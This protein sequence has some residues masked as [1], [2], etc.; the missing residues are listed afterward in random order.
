[1]VKIETCF[2]N[3]YSIPFL[4]NNQ[5]ILIP[6]GKEESELLEILADIMS[7]QKSSTGRKIIFSIQESYGFFPLINFSEDSP[8]LFAIY[9]F[10]D[11]DK[12]MN[13]IAS[14]A[15]G[16]ASYFI[17]YGGF[18]I[19]GALI[20]KN[21]CGIVLS[22]PSGIGKSTASKRIPPPWCS[23][24][25]DATLILKHDNGSYHAHPW[26]TW[27]TF[28]N[29]GTG[30]KWDTKK[31]VPL[32]GLFFLK[33][34]DIDLVEKIQLHNKFIMVFECI[35]HMFKRCEHNFREP[36]NI[37]EVYK[38][39]IKNVGDFITSVPI[40]LLQNTLSGKFWESIELIITELKS[41][42][43]DIYEENAFL[44]QNKPSKVPATSSEIF[45]DGHIPIL[46]SGYSMYPTLLPLDLLD[47]VPYKNRNPSIGD[48]ICFN[49]PNG[50][51]QVTHRIIGIRSDGYLTQGDNNKEPDDYFLTRELLTGY[52][53]GV[54]R[55]DK[56]YK[57]SFGIIGIYT[58]WK[59][60][61]RK[62]I[63]ILLQR[64]IQ[65]SKINTRYLGLY[66]LFLQ[67]FIKL[68][69]I[70]YFTRNFIVIRLFIGKYEIGEYNTDRKFWRI[71]FPFSIF[72]QKKD[73]PIIETSTSNGIE[74]E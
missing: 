46:F 15:F 73:L 69:Y 38:K 60:L 56:Y 40:Y 26:P 49:P 6:A 35:Q 67:K 34:S 30:G 62:K 61:I 3:N 54:I 71:K 41:N 72:F 9:P 13:K 42:Q 68:R 11:I 36:N 57:I 74:L 53:V 52:V 10:D 58:R 44:N 31:S 29:N 16:I 23:L 5:F 18:L 33:Q 66:N 12:K 27:S 70:M 28:F 8:K 37:R 19:H 39:E 14:C 64:I 20:E 59:V 51:K 24:S 48:I 32:K 55:K 65:K 7:L 45:S 21:G 63:T 4:F 50:E 43:D 22:G 47:V 1:M 2:S 25:D 17:P